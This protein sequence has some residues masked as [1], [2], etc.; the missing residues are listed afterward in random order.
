MAL[1]I[2]NIK[3]KTLKDIIDAHEVFKYSRVLSSTHE[4]C[5]ARKSMAE[6]H[7]RTLRK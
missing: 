4:A 6:K 2:R 3:Q 5:R 1:S 7:F